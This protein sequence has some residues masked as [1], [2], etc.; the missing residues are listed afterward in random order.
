MS[1]QRFLFATILTTVTI[2]SGCTHSPIRNLD[3]KNNNLY[4]ADNSGNLEYD[5]FGPVFSSVSGHAWDSCSGLAHQ[6][7]K[8]VVA[9]AKAKGGNSVVNVRWAKG[10]HSTPVP[11]C[12]NRWGWWLAYILPGLGPWMK[13]VEVYGT[14]AKIKG[15]EAPSTNV[16]LFDPNESLEIIATRIINK[17]NSSGDWL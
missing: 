12:V 13:N 11:H 1:R 8:E 4:S 2:V 14:A 10:D 5:D 17:L 6:A 3:Y 15:K 7:I 9:E 16:F